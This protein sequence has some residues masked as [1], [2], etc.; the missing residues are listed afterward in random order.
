MKSKLLERFQQFSR[1]YRINRK[2]KD[3]LFRLIFEDKEDLLALYNAI[4][5]TSYDNPD[6]LEITTMDNAI[7]MGIKNDLSFLIADELNLYEHQSTL[8]PNM[9]LRGF[10][11]FAKLYESY[12]AAH[13]LDIF[14]SRKLALPTPVFI[15]FYNGESEI[16][17][18][19]ALRLSDSFALPANGQSPALEC[20]AR[21]LNINYGHNQHLLN[22]CKRLN[23]Y[24]YFI[25]Q[26][27]IYLNAGYGLNGSVNLAVEDC[28]E[29]GILADILEKNR[30]EVIDMILTTFDKKLHDRTLRQEGFED[31]FEDGFEHHLLMLV[32][33]KFELGQSPEKIA[34]DLLESPET[35]EKCIK[36]IQNKN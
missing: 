35:V 32:R 5:S 7:Y 13:H 8:N 16:P 34:E 36:Q 4:N 11:Y 17:D 15:I 26:I 14:A 21:L 28:I 2:Y 10:L 20:T 9:P 25:A 3:R 22:R 24:S 12:V 30:S 18:E 31:G 33:K 23:D 1:K 6:D 19:Q 29:N 27:R